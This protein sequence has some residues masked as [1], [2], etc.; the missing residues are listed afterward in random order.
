MKLHDK[1]TLQREIQKAELLKVFPLLRGQTLPNVAFATT[2][3]NTPKLMEVIGIARGDSWKFVGV[4]V[5]KKDGIDL[6]KH[7]TREDQPYKSFFIMS[8]DRLNQGIDPILGGYRYLIPNKNTTP[9]HLATTEVFDTTEK[10][11]KEK[12]STTINLGRSFVD[13]QMLQREN[14]REAQLVMN[15]NFHILAILY[16]QNQNMK[17]FD[18]KITN[19]IPTNFTEEYALNMMLTQMSIQEQEGFMKAKKP[20]SFVNMLD[21]IYKGKPERFTEFY[22]KNWSNISRHLNTLTRTYYTT[23]QEKGEKSKLIT[24]GTG[25]YPENDT[26]YKGIE[27]AIMINFSDFSESRVEKYIK[28]NKADRTFQEIIAADFDIKKGIPY[29]QR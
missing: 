26:G 3:K 19:K 13:E 9:K 2:Y 29:Q 27:T 24:F 25:L 14:F 23:A 28:P 15:G 6:D 21:F 5:N 11:N 10:F 7:D 20:F 8:Q 1:A 22:E 17:A 16:L 18:G 4:N 12:F